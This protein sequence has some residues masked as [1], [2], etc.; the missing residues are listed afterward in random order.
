MAELIGATLGQYR[1]VDQIGEG[2][3]ATVYRA[4][5]H[6]LNRYVALK[7]LPPVHARQPGFTERF[8]REAEAVARL[9]HPNILPVF[10]FG[11]TED[12]S[13]I[14]MR[15]VEGARTLKERMAEPLDLAQVVDLIGQIAAALDCAHRLGIIHRDVKPSNV[16]MDGDWVLLGD[17]G[18]ARMTEASVRLTGSGV[19]VGTPAY[20]SP[21]QGQG[22]AL[23]HRT[24]VYSLGVILFEMLTGRIP[25]N[26]ET[27]FAIVLRRV[28]EPLP[29]PR[30]LNPQIPESVERVILK[31]L[32]R[33]PNDRYASAG[34]M[35]QALKD[36]ANGKPFP[37]ATDDA[38]WN[39]QSWTSETQPIEEPYPALE[40]SRP[41]PPA[42]ESMIADL[43][44]APPVASDVH[45]ER[46]YVQEPAPAERSFPWKW[47]LGG[48]AG[49]LV[50]A[51]CIVGAVALAAINGWLPFAATGT[52]SSRIA[53][54]PDAGAQTAA[55]GTPLPSPTAT[56]PAATATATPLPAATLTP[57]P[58][59]TPQPTLT[60]LPTATATPLP[61]ATPTEEPTDTPEPTSTPTPTATATPVPTPCAV[62]VG[63]RFSAIW[64]G[65]QARLGCPLGPAIEMYGA[66]QSFE[67]GYMLWTSEDQ[68]IH[69]LLQDGRVASYADTFQDGVDP[70]TSNLSPPAG[71]QEP[72]RGFGKVW[73]DHLGG[74]SSEIGWAKE[75]E[76]VAPGLTVQGFV[77]GFIFW[78][79]RVGARIVFHSG[80]WEQR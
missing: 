20:M 75:D 73:R 14:A 31:A 38:A 28:T 48:G 79:D 74:A 47:V 46:P 40:D 72:K 50:L 64:S 57:V 15:Y 22:V 25:H 59:H 19:G 32:A 5:Q 24:D 78:E 60:P 63:E 35:A 10:D 17:F 77:N 3:M 1:V 18:L 68:R 4:Y 33:D 16:L 42:K 55:T 45:T 37:E 29:M 13:Y 8:Q 58:T 61:T 62:A 34:E 66:G 2:G 49:V 52:P 53:A 9:N 30:T 65:D 80:A 39:V 51:A 54:V 27:P 67:R 71:L 44:A 70:E 12:Y 76:Y 69:V 21:E 56:Q 36:A 41:G 7:V 26:A 23:D 43:R 6:S 11:Q